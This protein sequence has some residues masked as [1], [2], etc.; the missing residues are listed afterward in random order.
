MR[1]EDPRILFAGG[2]TGGHVFPGVALA[3]H[4]PGGSAF[5]LCTARPFDAAQ[6]SQ[7]GIPFEALESP[8]WRGFRGFLGP[9]ARA[10]RAAA[11]R[12]REFRPDVLVGVGGYGTVPPVLAAVA[13][14]VPYVLLEQNIRPGKANRFLAPGASR[15]YAQWPQARTSFPGCGD[16]VRVTGSPLRR[17][18]RRVPRAEALRRFGLEEGR[19]TVAVVGG[20]Q[21]AEALNRGAVEGL[22]GAAG[23]LQVVHVAGA[24]QAEAVRGAYRS[25]GARAVVCDFVAD[26]EQ[27][28]SAADLVVCRAGAMTIAEIA[29]FGVPAVLV[30]IAR[31]SGDH[32]RENARAVARSGGGILMEE[33]DCLAGGLAPILRQL[34]SRD[35]VFD[36]MRDGLR[37]LARPEAARDIL[38]DL[39][40]VMDR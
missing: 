8:R 17:R 23:T 1:R 38:E 21:G 9:M 25:R 5:W 40:T 15:V 16:R 24:A 31:S 26:M 6:L 27:L 19:P 32:Q 22:D 36:R 30:P 7:E 14:G 39:R 35:P 20:S 12:I 10:L 18:L 28:Y 3:Q 37:A 13:A 29:A 33:R 34:A 4:V 11:R 2:G